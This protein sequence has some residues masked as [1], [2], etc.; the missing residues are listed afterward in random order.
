LFEAIEDKLYRRHQKL[1]HMF[2]II[3]T[4]YELFKGC[5]ISQLQYFLKWELTRSEL[6]S[7]EFRV[8]TCSVLHLHRHDVSFFS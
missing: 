3:T 8:I 2:K 5:A 7:V 1:L 4:C 6:K